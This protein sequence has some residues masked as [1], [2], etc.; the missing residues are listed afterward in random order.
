[1]PKF[2][3]CPIVQRN[4]EIINDQLFK[5][6]RQDALLYIY[7]YIYIFKWNILM[8]FSGKLDEKVI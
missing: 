2:H 5:I 7:I 3:S 4:P 1:M 6:C 8:K